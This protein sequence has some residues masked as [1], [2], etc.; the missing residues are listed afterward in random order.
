MWWILAG[1]IVVW[2]RRSGTHHVTKCV[3]PLGHAQIRLNFKALLSADYFAGCKSHC[4]DEKSYCWDAS[5]KIIMGGWVIRRSRTRDVYQ[6][7]FAKSE[8]LNVLTF[9]FTLRPLPFI[10]PYRS[11]CWVFYLPPKSRM[12][13]HIGDQRYCEP[14]LVCFW[15]LFL[16]FSP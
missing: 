6:I 9:T 16:I 3:N 1:A 13:D 14:R 15:A 10:S 12:A 7:R 11:L 4:D 2:L 5:R 8:V